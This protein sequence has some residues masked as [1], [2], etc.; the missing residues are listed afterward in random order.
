MKYFAGI[1]FFIGS[2]LAGLMS[3]LRA[4]TI[5]DH[6]PVHW[7]L[8]GQVDLYGSRTEAL[9]FVP[10]TMIGMALIFGLIGATTGNRLR[11]NATKAI[12][13]IS[14]GIVVFLLVIH[15]SLLSQ[16]KTDMLTLLPAM[17][18]GLLL[19][20]GFAIKGV[21]PNPFVGIRMPWTMNSPMVWRLTHDRASKSW[22]VGGGV[23]LL[24]SF[25]GLNAAIPILVFTGCVLYPI[26]DSYRISKT[27]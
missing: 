18:S 3:A 17:L 24:L 22:I 9:W 20:M 10:A 16:S 21:E 25:I 13:I 4:S 23:G 1:V 15:N 6:V 7:N 2:A 14:V 27:V 8:A 26:L 5:S 12:N 11:V 19:L